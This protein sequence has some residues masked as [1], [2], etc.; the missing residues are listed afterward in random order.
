MFIQL[1]PPIKV[2]KKTFDMFSVCDKSNQALAF[3][4]V[5]AT[6][7]GTCGITLS[8]IKF[9]VFVAESRGFQIFHT[10]WWCPENCKVCLAH[11]DFQVLLFDRIF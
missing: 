3:V 5:N 6:T 11:Q 2:L 4:P 7:E 10:K 9:K 1:K 8:R